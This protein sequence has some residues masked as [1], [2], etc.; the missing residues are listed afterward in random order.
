[1]TKKTANMTKKKP[2][3]KPVSLK[4]KIS[5]SKKAPIPKIPKLLAPLTP[6]K[7]TELLKTLAE[8]TTLDKKSVQKVL[9]ALQTIMKLHLAKKG[10]GQFVL[11]GIFKMTA[12]T[13]P[14]TKPRTGK[15]PFTGEEMVF[16]AKP[17]RKVVKTRILKKFKAEIE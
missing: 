11:P 16:K 5:A 3:T 8:Q 10:P 6:Y 2:A 12:I 14:A 15:N 9:D 4:S 1:M 17:A 13:K 7:K